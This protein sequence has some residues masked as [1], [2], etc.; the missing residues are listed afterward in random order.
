MTIPRRNISEIVNYRWFG[1]AVKPP[2]VALSGLRWPRRRID[3]GS[4]VRPP[5][6][7][8]PDRRIGSTHREF[9]RRFSH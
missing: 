9:C 1:D 2:L 4:G 8:C 5:C 7:N 6:L 3:S